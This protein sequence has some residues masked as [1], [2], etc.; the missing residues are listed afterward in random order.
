[1]RNI[2]AASLASGGADRA[3][4]LRAW[5]AFLTEPSASAALAALAVHLGGTR[6]R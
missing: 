3:G 4:L 5:L 1:M 2:A 6:V